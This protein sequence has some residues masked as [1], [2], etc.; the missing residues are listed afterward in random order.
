MSSKALQN[1]KV[2]QRFQNFQLPEKYKGTIVEKWFN[3]WKLL[4]GDYKEVA[5]D[6]W[7]WMKD[8]KIKTTIYGS[9]AAFMCYSYKNNPDEN[10]FFDQ[11]R[12]FDNEIGLVMEDQHNP[13]SA[14][15]LKYIETLNNQGILRRLTIGVVSF[16]WVH[17][18]SKSLGQYPA[19]CKYLK[20]EF[21]TFHE[22]IIDVGFLNKWWILEKKMQDFDINY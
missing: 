21:A 15:Y 9:L 20:P 13:V 19:V 16:M 7:Q 2:V 1:V 8:H 12:K 22:R 17:D 3:Y 4:G 18:Y 11:L 6:T 14:N 10:M 5:K